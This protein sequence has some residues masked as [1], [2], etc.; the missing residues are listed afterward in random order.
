MSFRK[1]DAKFNIIW[2]KIIVYIKMLMFINYI[3]T[4]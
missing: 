2:I 3:N 4:N 1:K